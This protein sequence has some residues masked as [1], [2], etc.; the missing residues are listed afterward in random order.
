VL[1]Q[2]FNGIGLENI[3]HRPHG[4]RGWGNCRRARGGDAG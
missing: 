4:G 1:A 3:F 2:A